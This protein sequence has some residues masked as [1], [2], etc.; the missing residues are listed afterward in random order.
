MA[1]ITISPLTPV[2]TTPNRRGLLLRVLDAI[3][4]SRTREAERIVSEHLMS[5][6]DATLERQGLDRVALRRKASGAYL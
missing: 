2:Q 3:I 6:D 4:E 5:L 1:T